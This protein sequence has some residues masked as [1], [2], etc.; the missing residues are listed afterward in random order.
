LSYTRAAPRLK[1]G[2]R[3]PAR[4]PPRCHATA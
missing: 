4:G 3:C 2:I 1:Q